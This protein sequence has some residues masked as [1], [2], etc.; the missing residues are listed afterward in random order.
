[1]VPRVVFK[2]VAYDAVEVAKGLVAL[3]LDAAPEAP[4]E[5]Q[6]DL[7]PVYPLHIGLTTFILMSYKRITQT[8][9]WAKHVQDK[10]CS[11][12]VFSLCLSITSK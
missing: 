5:L 9:K 6:S 3:D 10:K 11:G 12:H 1:M 8:T 7:E 2:C 4:S